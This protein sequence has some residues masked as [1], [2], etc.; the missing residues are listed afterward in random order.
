MAGSSCSRLNA[1]CLLLRSR[2]VPSILL[3]VEFSLLLCYWQ[4]LRRRRRR[5]RRRTREKQTKRLIIIILLKG[6]PSS[7]TCNCCIQR[8]PGERTMQ[9]ETVFVRH[10]VDETRRVSQVSKSLDID[11]CCGGPWSSAVSSISAPPQSTYLE[12]WRYGYGGK[13]K[14]C[15]D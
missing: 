11:S 6:C 1:R 12:I 3:N 9:L 8:W 14:T 15:I 4:L 10:V 7:S 5:T 2:P 13:R